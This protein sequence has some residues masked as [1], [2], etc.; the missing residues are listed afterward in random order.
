M[1]NLKTFIKKNL[2]TLRSPVSD[3]N[4]NLVQ[5]I[6]SILNADIIKAK[7]GSEVLTWVIPL[8]WKVHKGQLKDINGKV[9]IDYNNHPLYLWT[10]S[11]SFSGKI[12]KKE[13][14]NHILT[15]KTR[16]DVI[17]YHYK[18]GFST[19]KED[20]GFCIP[21]NEYMKLK[22]DEYI[23]EID[24]ELHNDNYM[25]TGVKNIDG[26]NKDRYIFAAHTCHPGIAIDGLT[27]VA[28]LMDIFKE[29]GNKN[30]KNTYTFVF[31]SEYYAAATF[32]NTLNDE[33]VKNIK[34][35]FFC[36][37]IGA[38][39]KLAYSSSFDG[40]SFV[41]K[42]VAHVFKH[43]VQDYN[44]YGYR[45]LI[46]ND[47]M[48]YNG[49]YYNIPTITLGQDMPK[50]YHSSQDNFENID[51]CAIEKYK[52]IILNIIDILETD[53]TPVL[54]YKGPLCL[55]RYDL[56]IDMKSNPDG[57]RHLELA[58]ILANAGG[59][60]TSCFEIASEIG[61]EYEFVKHFFDKLL[62]YNLA[63]RK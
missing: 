49:P 54:K 62:Y 28:L 27:N 31:G 25:M 61:A 2:L 7:C 43:K 12:S 38:N 6:A 46:G 47:E 63:E 23:V 40:A 24:T 10:N 55:S 4:N 48:F 58:Q 9:I 45:K 37:L 17:P 60:G 18:F 21:Y 20:W 16:P 42:V 19:K 44:S 33:D 5:N 41:D 8:Y 14:D 26:A 52:S 15:D 13:L 30:L 59:G 1:N 35:G 22:N 3:D 36:D 57:Y 51:F 56:Y 34:G 11:I 53:Y 32:L 50:Y 39:T 29:L